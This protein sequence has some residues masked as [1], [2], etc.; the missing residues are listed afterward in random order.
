MLLR[1]GKYRN[2]VW[3][4]SGPGSLIAIG[5]EL[6]SWEF[7][8]FLEVITEVRK[9]EIVKGEEWEETNRAKGRILKNR[10]ISELEAKE[11]SKEAE[12]SDALD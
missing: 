7:G 11:M 9:K 2:S 1:G 5:I 3:G 10:Y 12:W 8:L 4:R 6:E